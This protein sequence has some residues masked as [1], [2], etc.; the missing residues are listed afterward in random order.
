MRLSTL[1]AAL[2]LFATGA[3]AQA[4]P[5]A[6]SRA[7]FMKNVDNQFSNVDANHDGVIS[8]AELTAEQQKELTQAKAA[9]D[10]QL[11]ARFKQLD[12][13]KDGQLSPAEFA[14]IAPPIRTA[15]APAGL[16]QR[17]DTNKDGKISAAEYRA[18]QLARFNKVD[19]NHD[20]TASI[21]EQKAGSR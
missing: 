16:L 4:P 2:S 1:A 17:L 19:A 14:A 6:I 18:P 12:T 8:A 5:K 10:Q 7:D 15:E 9:V 21:E 13:N 20:G 3:F 11:Q